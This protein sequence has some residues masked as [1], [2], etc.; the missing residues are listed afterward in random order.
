MWGKIRLLFKPPAQTESK[1]SCS[2]SSVKVLVALLQAFFAATTLYDARGDQITRYGYAAFGLTV[3][4]YLLMSLVNLVG[5]LVC[6]EYPAMYLVENQT[7]RNILSCGGP[8]APEDQ[9]EP[10]DD[11]QEQDGNLEVPPGEREGLPSNPEEQPVEREEHPEREGEQPIEID[12]IV[13]VLLE[14][15]EEA[16][17]KDVKD[18]L[19]DHSDFLAYSFWVICGITLGV[20]GGLSRFHTG[21]SSL[22]E[23]VWSMSWLVF[24]M[25][26][27]LI[28]QDFAEKMEDR[29]VLNSRTSTEGAFLFL[30]LYSAPAIG[31]LVVVGRMINTYGV[32]VIV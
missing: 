11:G 30:L 12:G 8:R 22:A 10:R 13:G 32:C 1:I 31:G 27:G 26:F 2:Y 6:P 4:P 24:G 21:S 18:L 7:L 29:R 15:T 9:E 14:D 23:R 16:M 20:I 25:V 17:E 28:A 19:I 5:N 3:T